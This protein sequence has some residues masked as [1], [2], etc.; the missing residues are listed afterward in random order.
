M[1]ELRIQRK[2]TAPSPWWLVLL[3]GAIVAAVAYFYLRPDA[4]DDPAPPAN[5]VASVPTA[6]SL[7]PGSPAAA[8]RATPPPAD[9]APGVAEPEAEAQAEE[10]PVT[11]AALA[12]QA[13]SDPAAPAY[14]LTGLQMLAATLV[15]LADRP[16]L[17]TT[18]VL[19]QR[20]NLTSATS[21]L[22]APNAPLRAGFVAAA[23]LLQ[24]MQQQAAP[25]QDAAANDLVR[26]A[27]ELSGRQIT[28]VEQHQNQQFLTQAAALVQVLNA[29]P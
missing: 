22:A 16:D 25:D 10:T 2:K 6:D 21:R 15:S 28:P 5:G 20:D 14:A 9:A 18:A 29:T 8:A 11:P 19:E 1:A 4:P 23:S 24:A 12:A 3:A 26:L 17:R 27:N 7:A 13:A